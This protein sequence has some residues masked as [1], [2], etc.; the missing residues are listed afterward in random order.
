MEPDAPEPLEP[1]R[2]LTPAEQI[3]DPREGVAD[4]RGAVDPRKRI[5]RSGG[6]RGVQQP[7]RA[8]DERSR[9]R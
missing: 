7:G 6:R 1:D 8:K 5:R 3:K 2:I 9:R 4:A